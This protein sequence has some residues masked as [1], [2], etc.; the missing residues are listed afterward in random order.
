MKAA[1]LLVAGAMAA[2]LDLTVTP[3]IRALGGHPSVC[4]A[5][6]AVWAVL[7]RREEAM[8]LAPATGLMLGLLGNEPLGASIVGL[9]PAVLLASRRDPDVTEGRFVAALG[10]AAVSAAAYVAVVALAGAAT[11]GGIP[12]P[13]ETLRAMAGTAVLTA[14]IAALVYWPVARAAWQPRVRGQFRR[15]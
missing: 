6:V 11:G 1:L 12:S 3:G 14:P 13:A 10:I 8:V 7:R 4:V 15:Y 2:L 5:L 9:A